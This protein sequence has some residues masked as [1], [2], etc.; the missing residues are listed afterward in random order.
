MIP[1]VRTSQAVHYTM[2]LPVVTQ[3]FTFLH[4]IRLS[5]VQY[6]SHIILPSFV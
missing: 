2:Q 4:I 5:R 6:F 1:A 3:L